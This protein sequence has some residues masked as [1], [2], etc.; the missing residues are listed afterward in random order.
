MTREGLCAVISRRDD[1]QVVGEASHGLEA[2]DL[3]RLH[4][5]DVVLMDMSMPQMDGL[6]TTR[7]IL[8]EFP[9]ARII[10]F[11]NW[12]GDET[13]YQAMRAGA[14]AY[15]LK[16]ALAAVLLETIEAVAS[17][18]TVLQGALAAKATRNNCR[19]NSNA[20][21]ISFEAARSCD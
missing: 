1:M 18:Q 17:G 20:I 11:S 2:V 19:T 9:A 21:L 4:T 14:K 15:L 6:Q 16:D 12:D 8:A 7:T 10:I 3:Y 5:P 13:V